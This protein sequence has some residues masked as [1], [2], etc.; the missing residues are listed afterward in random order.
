VIAPCAVKK[1]R[2]WYWTGHAGERID[3]PGWPIAVLALLYSVFRILLEALV[4]R[5]RS[6]ASLRLELLVLRHQLRVLERQIKRPRW[7]PRDRLLL[8]GLSQRLPRTSWLSFLVSPETLLRWHRALVQ[9]KW[10]IFA[11]RPRRGRPGL[12]AERRELILRL[13]RENTRWGYRRIQGELLK[14]GVRCSHETIRSRDG[15]PPAPLRAQ[16]SW[17]QFL[18]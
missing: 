13:A 3:L 9:R 14:L 1:P 11:R 10:A 18:H 17:R 6:D 15:L 16:T 4:D 7:R 12:V 5:H 2:T 8:A